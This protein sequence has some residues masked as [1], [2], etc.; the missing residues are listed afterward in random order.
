MP[1]MRLIDQHQDLLAFIEYREL[2]ERDRFL[3]SHF[4][5]GDLFIA[6]RLLLLAHDGHAHLVLI[7]YRFA[8]LV[9]L[10]HGE[11]D[12]RRWLAEQALGQRRRRLAATPVVGGPPVT[13]PVCGAEW[14]SSRWSVTPPP[15]NASA[16]Q[17]ACAQNC[18]S[19][20]LNPGVPDDAAALVAFRAPA[21]SSLPADG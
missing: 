1:A 19:I 20:Y 6:A 11:H 4:S 9:F 12:V 18:C 5:P 3:K 7:R 16:L 13:G 17:R 2:L 14:S 8:I 21:S 10:Q 15:R